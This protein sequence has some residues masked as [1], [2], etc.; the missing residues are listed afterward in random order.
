MRL[1][2]SMVL[3]VL[4][5]LTICFLGAAY[6]LWF[7]PAGLPLA[8]AGELPTTEPGTA[9]SV[10]GGSSGVKLTVAKTGIAALTAAQLRSAELEF[11]ELSSDELIL[12]RNGEAV[13]FTVREE[14]D[15]PTLYFYAEAEEDPHRPLA[16]YELRPGAGISMNEQNAQPFN[17]GKSAGEHLL[18]WE[19]NRFFVEDGTPGDAWMGPLLLAP[20]RW[21]L[22]LDTIRPD[23]GA[24]V[25]AVHLF[26]NIETE[27]DQQHHVDVLVND[28]SVAE[29]FWQGSGQETIRVPLQEGILSSSNENRIT[30][31]VHDDRMP[32][33]EAIYVDSLELAYEGPVDVS[34]KPVTFKGRA[35]NLRIDGAGEDLLVFDVSEPATPV[36]LTDI[37]REG[38]SA[39]LYGGAKE[40][41][42]TALNPETAVK[43]GVETARSWEKPLRDPAWEADYLTIVA[44]VRGFDQA[45]APLLAHRQ[46]QG[47]RVASVSVEQIYDE[48]GYGKRDP[49]AIKDFITYASENWAPP[50][51]RYVLL[52][53]DATYDV[54][55][56]TPGKNRNRL[57]TQLEYT[58][59]GSYVASDS[60]F[61]KDEENSMRAAVGRF[62]AQNAPQL[63]A[64]VKKSIDY[65]EGLLSGDNAWTS[66]ALL[67]ADDETMYDAEIAALASYLDAND[68]AVYRLHISQDDFTHDKII[69]AINEGVGLVTYMGYGSAGTWGDEAVL[70]NSDVQALNNLA[71]LPIL[72]TFTSRSA[73]FAEPRNDSLAESFLR[74]NNGGII[75]SV[76]LSGHLAEE[77]Q[78]RLTALFFEQFLAEE[79]GRL[80]DSL[81]SMHNAASEEPLLQEAMAPVNLLGDPALLI[82]RPDGS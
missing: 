21:T 78:P 9:P 45:I 6:T 25:L 82:D 12:T 36:V 10:A 26:T 81:L 7:N 32:L 28:R 39:H 43:P 37:R 74:A 46:E 71:Q 72:N 66:K 24:A 76:A 61:V 20:E 75:A 1:N 67:V 27:G 80:G 77:F 29:H 40:A 14:G 50:G 31:V 79:Q 54:T 70:Q 41:T 68:Y 33:G 49:Q 65:E 5:C 55:D 48:F 51:P 16:V 60:W 8:D 57:P 11:P 17:E 13:P 62:P 38:D 69:S 52:V 44:D 53:G 63:R 30:I 56:R 18:D 47:L 22:H 34:S 15:E 23:G 64:M 2:R 73:A 59:E 19:E 4:A 58:L 42:L 3:F 35:P